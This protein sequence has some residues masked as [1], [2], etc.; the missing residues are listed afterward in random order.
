MLC[1]FSY[2]LFGQT[3]VNK[4]WIVS[5]DSIAVFPCNLEDHRI[6]VIYAISCLGLCVGK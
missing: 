3:Q 2:W 1:D 5:M 4:S 6:I